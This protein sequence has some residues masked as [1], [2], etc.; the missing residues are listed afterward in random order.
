MRSR[1]LTLLLIPALLMGASGAC[2]APETSG[3]PAPVVASPPVIAADVLQAAIADVLEAERAR[4]PVAEGGDLA[5]LYTMFEGHAI[6]FDAVGRLT[7]QGRAARTLLDAAASEGLDPAVYGAPEIAR[8]ADDTNVEASRLARL[9]VLLSSGLLRYYRDV[10]MGRVDPRSLDL[11]IDVVADDH[12][13]VE[14]VRV[15]IDSGRIAETA[16]ELAPR[17]AQYRLLKDALARYRAR[18]AEGEVELDLPSTTLRP[19]DHIADLPALHRLL[20]T[21]GDLP[22]DSVAPETGGVYG[23]EMQ[24]GVK[25]FQARHGLAADGAIGRATRA[26]LQVPLSWRVRQ[27]ELSMERLRWLPDLSSGRLIAV[28]I[29]MFRLWAWNHVPSDDP[30]VLSMNVIVGRALDTRTPVFTDTMTFVVFRPYWNVPSSILRGEMLPAIRKD[31]GYIQRQNLEIVAGPADRSPVLDPTPE[32]IARLGQGGVRIRQRPGPANALGL[33]KF[34]FPNEN[35]IYLH[36]TPSPG[37]FEQSR[38]DFSHGCIRVQ[39]PVRLAEWVLGRNDGWT[40]ERIVAARNGAPNVYVNLAEPIQMVLY[41]TTAIV[42]PD[43]GLVYF[44]EDI[45]NQDTR[46]DTAL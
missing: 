14:M 2:S 44:A 15:A 16:A 31:P 45:Y 22:A 20:V 6:W 39:D 23:G 37:L 10:H 12:D 27:I 8:L 3:Q 9:D 43:D 30:P 25:R 32:N 40:R 46:L 17:I 41:Y 36:D 18:A 1:C 28:N 38:R 4:L 13:L 7:G 21:L 24:T 26:A 33:T 11:Q 29:P 5:R 34:M 35:N 19:G 42:L